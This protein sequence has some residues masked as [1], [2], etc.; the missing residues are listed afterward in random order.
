[1]G[2]MGAIA[3]LAQASRHNALIKMIRA[4]VTNAPERITNHD[5]GTAFFSVWL[6]V[7]VA[8]GYHD[9]R[10]EKEGVSISEIASEFD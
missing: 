6:C 9:L 2:Y 5:A 7:A 1:M 4:R 8:L 10:A 3:V